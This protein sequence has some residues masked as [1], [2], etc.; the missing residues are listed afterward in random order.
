MKVMVQ[1]AETNKYFSNDGKWTAAPD[2]A[3]DFSFS[4]VAYEFA[5]RRN[6]KAFNVLFYYPDIQYTIQIMSN[7]A[8]AN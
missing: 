7:R 2:E 4:F 8:I 5:E 1:D 3:Q 6:V